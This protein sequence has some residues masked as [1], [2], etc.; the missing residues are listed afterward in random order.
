MARR[1]VSR[2]S[3]QL[4]ACVALGVHSEHLR[5]EGYQPISRGCSVAGGVA[6]QI[7][8]GWAAQWA[9]VYADET[10]TAGP[11]G[12]LAGGL[13]GQ[14]GGTG[15]GAAAGPGRSGAGGLAMI[16]PSRSR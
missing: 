3:R 1:A 14:G 2:S 12:G 15:R 7:R 5:K 16:G 10:V 11:A 6:M 9:G 13:L 4:R 8:R